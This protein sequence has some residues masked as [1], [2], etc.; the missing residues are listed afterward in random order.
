[1]W[2]LLWYTRVTHKQPQHKKIMRYPGFIT[3]NYVAP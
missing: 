3:G 1:M 2:V